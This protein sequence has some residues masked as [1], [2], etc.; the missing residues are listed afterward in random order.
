MQ[1][2]LPTLQKCW[3]LTGP[4]ACGK[5]A[6]A[7]VLAE[8]IN[9]EIVALDS[10]SLYR[11]MDVGTAKPTLAERARVPHHLIDILDPHEDYTVVEYLQ[12]ALHTCRDIVRR[13]RTPL[14]VGGAGLYLRA[15]LRGV[16]DGPPADWEFR[17]RLEEEAAHR[18]P[19]YLHAKLQ[20]VDPAAARRLPP[21]DR[22]RL[23]RALEVHHL[24]GRPASEQQRQF[25]LPPEERPQHVYWLHPPRD[26]LYQRINRRVEAMLVAGL[27]DEVRRLLAGPPLSR[28]AAQ[29]LGYAEMIAMLRGEGT[30]ADAVDAIQTKTRQFAKR[31]H[32][33]F[34]NL[35]ECTAVAVTGDETPTELAALIQ[36]V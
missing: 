1:F 16:F 10:M 33:W 35:E 21:Q 15:I 14:F 7:P 27:V 4:T 29:A 26:R 25:P 18:P 11:G 6:A 31:Q 24:T 3:F 30:L 2:D 36:T 9:A 32:T 5:T 34:R 13:G 23:I 12:S 8:R 20:A 22:R 28:T 17:R 19:E